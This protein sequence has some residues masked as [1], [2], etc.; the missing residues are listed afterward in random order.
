LL[1][2][3]IGSTLR[4]DDGVAHRVLDLLGER[5]QVHTRRVVQ[6]TPEM[7]AEFPPAGDVVLLDADLAPGEVT[8]EAVPSAAART[9]LAHSL[10]VEELVALARELFGFRGMAYLCRVPGVDFG[11]GEGLSPQA[12]AN[13]Q[14]AAR[15][16]AAWMARRP[17]A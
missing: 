1:L 4:R 9:P 14:A 6:L 12:E 13:A 3:A 17:A 15:C 11:A 16:L 7:V 5:P 2:I 10:R 8:V